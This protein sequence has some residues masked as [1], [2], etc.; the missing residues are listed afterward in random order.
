[1][2]AYQTF[3]PNEVYQ[4]GLDSISYN[5][6]NSLGWNG[7]WNTGCEHIT[8]SAWS[9]TSEYISQDIAAKEAVAYD[10]EGEYASEVKFDN[11]TL[12]KTDTAFM[13]VEQVL[14][15]LDW[16]EQEL[17]VSDSE[18]SDNASDSLSSELL[19]DESDTTQDDFAKIL[20]EM[21][22]A[23]TDHSAV[24]KTRKPQ[25]KKPARAHKRR[26]IAQ[27]EEV[28]EA[29]TERF[30]A[31]AATAGLLRCPTIYSDSNDSRVDILAKDWARAMR[32]LIVKR[33]WRKMGI[34]DW[35]VEVKLLA[36]VNKKRKLDWDLYGPFAKWLKL[37]QMDA[38]VLCHSTRA[39]I[40]NN[41]LRELER[42]ANEEMA[43]SRLALVELV[44]ADGMVIPNAVWKSAAQAIAD[45]CEKRGSLTLGLIPEFSAAFRQNLS[46]NWSW[47]DY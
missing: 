18:P 43:K 31:S 41:L 30:T 6:Y 44:D 46:S 29:F 39:K 34:R 16:S 13:P 1:M 40:R 3:S 22:G 35:V 38:Q 7:V 32:M 11:Q 36:Q 26:T 33:R 25:P 10:H 9:R 42:I 27:V 12:I 8:E 15:T 2:S 47:V 23:E 37:Y 14:G 20:A 5:E 4:A 24:Q 19:F 17:P 21:E 45:D 28:D